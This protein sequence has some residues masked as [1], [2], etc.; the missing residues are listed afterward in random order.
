MCIRDRNDWV[1]PVLVQVGKCDIEEKRYNYNAHTLKSDIGAL[2]T[3]MFNFLIQ[4]RVN[5]K[6]EFDVE[7]I[8]RNLPE[9]GLS[10]RNTEF[11]EEEIACL[12]YTS[13]CV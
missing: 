4:G 7:K 6:L 3:Q 13:R 9:L 10:V 2:K 12:L 11:I 5:E 8:E 1:E